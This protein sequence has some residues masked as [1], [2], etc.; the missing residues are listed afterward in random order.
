MK[1]KLG[2]LIFILPL[3]FLAVV[4]TMYMA[5]DSVFMGIIT[6]EVRVFNALVVGMMLLVLLLT[7]VMLF[8]TGLKKLF[9]VN[10][11]MEMK[12]G[13]DKRNSL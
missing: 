4:S 7:L 1:Q 9:G 2:G 13:N 11:F 3:L 5:S 6:W 10:N 12:N 8:L